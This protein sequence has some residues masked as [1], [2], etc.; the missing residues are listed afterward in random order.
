MLS[1]CEHLQRLTKT[2]CMPAEPCCQNLTKIF[3]EKIRFMTKKSG[4]IHNLLINAN[5]IIFSRLL[6]SEILALWQHCRGVWIEI[7]ESFPSQTLKKQ[8]KS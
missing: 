3:D 4:S 5:I 6:E 7:A 8:R 2:L 1:N